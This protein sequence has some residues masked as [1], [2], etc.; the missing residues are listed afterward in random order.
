M[1]KTANGTIASDRGVRM[2]NILRRT[3]TILSG[4]LVAWAANATAAPELSNSYKFQLDDI[5]VSLHFQ[6][7]Q[8][9]KYADRLTELITIAFCEY[10]NLFGGPPKRAD[11]QPYSSLRVD[12][13]RGLGGEANAQHLKLAISDKKM[14]GFYNW[15][16]VVLHELFHLW[17][18][19]TFRYADDSEQWFN[20]GVT[21]YY[22]FR[23]AAKFGILARDKVIDAFVTPIGYYLSAN[24]LGQLSLRQAGSTKER[25]KNHYFLVYHGG[26][27]VGLLLNQQIRTKTSGKMSLDNL[28]KH[29]YTHYSVE[30]RYTM[31]ALVISLRQSTSLDF[32]SFFR[33]YV[34]GT[35][36][37]PVGE[38]VDLGALYFKLALEP[39][40]LKESEETL[41]E[42][43][44]LGS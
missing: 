25:K 30:N 9:S 35:E 5:R 21:E 11:G 3:L 12:V 42:V 32:S 1:R 4:F 24:G 14:F 38:F 28:L 18:A 41:L 27:T 40:N 39:K 34:D 37:I 33:R 22:T 8:S 44:G 31:N 20:E 15:E 36:I 29:L 10:S 16:M 23:T 6:D 43:L 19:E 17:S 13:E 7:N 26:F 2:Q